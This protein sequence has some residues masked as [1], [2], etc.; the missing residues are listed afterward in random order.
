[1]SPLRQ[2]VR[3]PAGR[4]VRQRQQFP[5][6]VE[7]SCEKPTRVIVVGVHEKARLL[8]D[9]LR[10][11]KHPTYDVV[12]HVTEDGVPVTGE[13]DVLGNA[14]E[15][16]DIAQRLDIDEV[17]VASVP[18]W[19]EQLA[20]DAST[21]SGGRPKIRLVPS[22]YETMLCYP[23][24][25]RVKDL[26]LVTLNCERPAYIRL[27]KRLFDVIFSLAALVATAPITALAAL[28]MKFSS[29]GPV[30]FR[31][32]RV[33]LH[34]EEFVLF[35]LRTMVADAEKETGPVLCSPND[36]RVTVVGRA[37]RRLKI[38]EL[39]QFFNVLKGDM[40]VVGPRP[41][42]KWF[43]RQF[44]E[45]I[46]GYDARHQV[47][48]GITGLA[49]VYGGYTTDPEIKL[50]YDLLYVYGRSLLTDL[51]IIVLTLPSVLGRA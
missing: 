19:L 11:S 17:I 1:M 26:P 49:Q 18:S 25:E 27:T 51:K 15:M 42:R 35:K 47:R 21:N 8:S 38:D 30:L 32:P 14:S 2:A 7:L 20:Q 10:A 16:F 37:L 22:A 46:P 44:G 23:K 9:A 34:G 48:P 5:A 4:K 6:G 3:G 31:Q 28:L 40:S 45:S 43:V 50:K 12:G 29:R 33:G 24:L 39:P 36:D 13:P 41:E